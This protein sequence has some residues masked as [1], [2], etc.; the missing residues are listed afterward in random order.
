[1]LFL[2]HPAWLWLKKFD[3][4][5]LP[6]VDDDLQALFDAG[7]EFESYAEQLFPNA[8]RLSFNNYREYLSLPDKTVSEINSGSQTILQGRLEVEGLTCIFD[9]LQKVNNK[10]FDLIEIKASTKAKPEHQYDLAFQSLI[11]EKSGYSVRNISVIHVDKKYHKSGNIDPNSLCAQTDITQKVKSLK[12]FT[13][14]QVSSAKSILNQEKK[15]DLS[16]RHVNQTGVPG[17]SNWF[18]EWMDIFKTLKPSNK[19]YSIYNLSYPNPE[20]IAKLED[21]NI[22]QIADIPEKLA[23]RPKQSAQIKTTKSNKPILNKIKIKKFLNSFQ[24]PLYFFDYETMSSVIPV[25]NNMSPYQ[26]YPFQYSLHVLSSPESEVQ[27]YE[28]LHAKNSNPVPELLKKMQ[29]HF[30]NKGTILTWNKRY[31]KGCNKRMMAMYPDY[32]EFL[33]NLNKRIKDLMTPFSKMW[34]FHKDFFGSA[35]IKKVLPVLVPE[36]SYDDLSV[37]NGLT[38]RRLWT[39][40]ILKGENQDKKSEILENLSKYCT[41]DTLA[42]VKIFEKLKQ[43]TN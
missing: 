20:Q 43:I 38:A 5:K 31:E 36:L 41:L 2:R 27:H 25:F 24:Y 4:S 22:K 39:Q 12:K 37:G 26:D 32:T 21:K 14:Q 35:S 42:M 7:H 1:M 23:L 17:V 30:E 10:E 8:T 33:T 11:L 13:L 3:K 18:Q 6:P 9:V 34:Y 28:Y 29:K 16:P 40:T 19:P 15:P